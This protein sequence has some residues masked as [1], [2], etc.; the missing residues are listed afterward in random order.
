MVVLPQSEMDLGGVVRTGRMAHN[1]PRLPASGGLLCRQ[2]ELRDK[3]VRQIGMG[4]GKRLPRPIT[5]VGVIFRSH[6][7]EK[8]IGDCE[9]G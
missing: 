2:D 9:K 3:T 4:R 5:T 8:K 7:G 1:L 6:L